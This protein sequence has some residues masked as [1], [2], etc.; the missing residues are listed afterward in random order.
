MTTS[1]FRK[2][3]DTEEYTLSIAITQ[4]KKLNLFTTDEKSKYSYA[5]D[6]NM[7][8]RPLSKQ[9]ALLYERR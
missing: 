3:A 9:L 7:R 4:T 8:G 5:L 1:R 2:Q 6:I